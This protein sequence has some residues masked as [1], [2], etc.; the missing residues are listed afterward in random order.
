MGDSSKQCNFSGKVVIVTGSSS[1]IGASTAILFAKLGASVVITGR[2]VENLKK[3]EQKCKFPN[4][5]APLALQADLTKE[6]DIKKIVDCTVQR[7]GKIDVLVNNAGIFEAGTLE[8][9]NLEQ[10]DRIFNTN[11]RAVFHLTQLCLPHLTK[12]E[13]NIIN[14]SSV[15]GI[16]S[17]SSYLVYCMSKSALD[18]FTK[19]ISAELGPKKIRVNSV[20]PGMILTEI[21]AKLG[22]G[23]EVVKEIIKSGTAMHPIGRAG[24]PEE[25]AD[26]IAFLASSKAGF[27]TGG[28]YTIDGGY[29]N[30]SASPSA[31]I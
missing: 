9:S 7:F 17:L 19:C 6:N 3:V 27:I 11:I 26:L 16:K 29:C 4:V 23:E 25:V 18:Q 22:A 1:G 8:Q 20:N 13:G 30:A 5:P 24:Q 14:I 10:L 15:A 31:S 28:I 12:T 21:F 2:N